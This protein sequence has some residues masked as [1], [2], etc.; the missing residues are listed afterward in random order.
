MKIS[1]S[2]GSVEN[3]RREIASALNCITRE[4]YIAFT[5]YTIGT[6]ETNRR[7]G[8]APPHVVV[9]TVILY[10]LDTLAAFIRERVRN[11]PSTHAKSLL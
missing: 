6:E 11:L 10:P 5:G 4:D 9:G 1:Q 2:E 8:V 7:R 3:R